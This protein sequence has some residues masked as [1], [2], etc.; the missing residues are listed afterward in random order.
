M[1][2]GQLRWLKKIELEINK[3]INIPKRKLDTKRLYKVIEVIV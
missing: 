1:N 3:G 2:L